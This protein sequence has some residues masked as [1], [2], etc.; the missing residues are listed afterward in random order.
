M[1]KDPPT[2]KP[3]HVGH[4]DHMQTAP[5]VHQRGVDSGVMRQRPCALRRAECTVNQI[6][7]QSLRR[8]AD[9]L[10]SQT[11][12]NRYKISMPVQTTLTRR[13]LATAIEQHP[14]SE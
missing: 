10:G 12:M 9:Q 3:P 11:H 8:I 13:P 2:G 14:V 1:P 5:T 7:P 4:A 6:A